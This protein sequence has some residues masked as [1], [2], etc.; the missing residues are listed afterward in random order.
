MGD[1]LLVAKHDWE[2]SKNGKTYIQRLIQLG[3]DDP[4]SHLDRVRGKLEKI[5]EQGLQKAGSKEKGINKGI[6]DKWKLIIQLSSLILCRTQVH[7]PSICQQRRNRRGAPGQPPPG[8]REKILQY[9]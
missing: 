9:F 4:A 3:I 8:Y 1:A 5:F 7:H 2:G 6:T